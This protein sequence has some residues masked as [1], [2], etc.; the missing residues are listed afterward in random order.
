MGE[1]S[2]RPWHEARQRS[3]PSPAKTMHLFLPRRYE[4]P[5]GRIQAA[6]GTR[7]E[8]EGNAGKVRF[9]WGRRQAVTPY[10]PPPPPPSPLE[11]PGHGAER[12]TSG[13]PGR[14]K[15]LSS[16]LDTPPYRPHC[17]EAQ[18]RFRAPEEKRTTGRREASQ[19]STPSPSSNNLR[20]QR[21]FVTDIGKVQSRG[22]GLGK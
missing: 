9:I 13:T 3:L 14:P 5:A 17:R 11:H 7:R 2:P 8:L 22:R 4:P 21:R 1:I 10:A 15:S 6:L 20:D 12:V 16:R 18:G 19:T